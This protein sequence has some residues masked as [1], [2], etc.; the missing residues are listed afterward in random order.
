MSVCFSL[1]FWPVKEAN[2]SVHGD[3]LF[4]LL[5]ILN[6]KEKVNRRNRIPATENGKGQN[7]WI[8]I[9]KTIGSNKI[10]TIPNKI[11]YK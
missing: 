6:K 8:Q 10:V 4:N 7:L 11:L 1:S 9:C 2:T 5:I 3:R